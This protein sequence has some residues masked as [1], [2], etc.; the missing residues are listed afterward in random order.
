MSDL[1]Y[2]YHEG[3]NGYRKK[4]HLKRDG[5]NFAAKKVAKQ[6]WIYKKQL[7]TCYL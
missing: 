4:N 1:Y 5:L 7:E 3:I 2:A 6:A